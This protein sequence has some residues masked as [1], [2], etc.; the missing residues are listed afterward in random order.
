MLS[1]GGLR[2]SMEPK[3]P[4]SAVEE[5]APERPKPSE[6]EALNPAAQPEP[7]PEGS[8][9]EDTHAFITPVRR[10]SRPPR[11]EAERREAEGCR[12]S[13]PLGNARGPCGR[14]MWH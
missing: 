14:L 11:R 10:P 4:A 8:S 5:G 3:P 13:A 2:P 7:E 9:D 12:L 1:A 6:R